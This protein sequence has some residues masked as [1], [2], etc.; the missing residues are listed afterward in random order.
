MPYGLELL[1][2]KSIVG[3][4]GKITDTRTSACLA[5]I[6]EA[7]LSHEAAAFAC[8]ACQCCMRSCTHKGCAAPPFCS[9]VIFHVLSDSSAMRCVAAH[10]SCDGSLH[11]PPSSMLMCLLESVG[12]PV[13]L[14]ML[15]F[16]SLTKSTLLER[17]VVHI[18]MLIS[19]LGP[20]DEAYSCIG[21]RIREV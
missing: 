12:G 2:G 13:C 18:T 20:H 7:M 11:L 8:S 5:R 16:D 14:S 10:A 4:D 17:C 19:Q 3:N 21:K 9:L 6:A 1:W 15:A